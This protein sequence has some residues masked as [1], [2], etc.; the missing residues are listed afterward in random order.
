MT[1]R[2]PIWLEGLAIIALHD[3]SLAL[4][5]GPSGVRDEGLLESALQR[6]VNRFFYE[7]E[8]SI[9]ALA[10]TYAVGI[11][12]NHPFVDGNKRA[13]Y[14]ALILF[15]ALNGAP[16]K[17]DKADAVTTMLAVAAGRMDIDALADWIRA[18]SD[19]A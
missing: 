16:L 4:H 18:N 5:G 6:P 9:A 3:R 10:A 19:A 8:T 2:E 11:A 14:Q 13:A 12:S 15:L 17:A 7:S 1:V